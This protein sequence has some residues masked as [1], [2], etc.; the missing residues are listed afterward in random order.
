MNKVRRSELRKWIAEV[1]NLLS[2]G[3]V[4]KDKLENICFEEENYFDNMPENLQGS[5]RG[6]T[7]EE[8]IDN[9]NEGIEYI[10]NAIAKIEKAID[11][12]RSI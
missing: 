6:M 8:A 4:L 10:D 1:N 2:Q 11:C 12:I 9:M 3:E 7:S 5:M